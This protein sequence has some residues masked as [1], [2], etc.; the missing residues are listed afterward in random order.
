MHDLG[1]VH[2]GAFSQYVCPSALCSLDW[3]PS[4]ETP[5]FLWVARLA[6]AF[7]C[8]REPSAVYLLPLSLRDHSAVLPSDDEDCV[9]VTVE[10]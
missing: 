7:P 8:I 1:I 4:A 3:R 6:Y 10:G 5:P 2:L 9:L